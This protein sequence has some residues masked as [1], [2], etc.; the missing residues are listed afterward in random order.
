MSNSLLSAFLLA[1]TLGGMVATAL[2]HV[3]MIAGLNSRR[4]VS[5]QISYLNRDFLGT[6]RA[7][8]HLYPKS[9]LPWILALTLALSIACGLG[10]AFIES[11]G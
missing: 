5:S 1:T 4:N 11:S 9:A 7:H 6:F 3:A 2:M 8:R 10:F